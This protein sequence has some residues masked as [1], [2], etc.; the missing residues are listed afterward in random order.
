MGK[1]TKMKI[2]AFSDGKFKDKG[3]YYQVMM[4]PESIKWDGSVEYNDTQASDSAN[5]SSKYKKSL[6]Q[7]LAFDLV[8]DCTGVVDF[9]RLNLQQEVND[10]KDIIYSFQGD[11]HRPNFVTIHWGAE[12]VFQGV[13]TNFDINYEY[14]KP[15]GNALR[16]KIS[17]KFISYTDI[18]RADK[19]ENKQSPD[20]THL[21]NVAAG[22]S[23]PQLSQSIYDT[24][25]YVVQLAKANGLN[26]FRH[27]TAGSQLI[28]P[29]LKTGLG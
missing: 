29:P 10:L 24:T 16:A 21:I 23:L 2:V 3:N 26:K 9:N 6:A 27:L 5:P 11:S 4:N 7:N 28:F 13:L 20:M 15:N 17:L 8:I 25:D 12:F 22:D 14:F 19:K 1:L 18:E